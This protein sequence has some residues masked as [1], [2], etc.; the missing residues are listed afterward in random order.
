ME[1]D[2]RDFEQVLPLLERARQTRAWLVLAGHEIG[3]E[4]PQTTRTAM[5]EKL[6]PYVREPANGFWVAPVWVVARHIRQPRGSMT[7]RTPRPPRLR[8]P[9]HSPSSG[10]RP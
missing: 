8:G 5:L 1:M 7:P 9:P 4:G 2:G 6:L 10:S 3:P